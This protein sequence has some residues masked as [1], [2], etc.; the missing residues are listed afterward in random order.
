MD[1]QMEGALAKEF[2]DDCLSTLLKKA[3]DY[4]SEKDCFSNFKFIAQICK[5]PIEKTF[6]QFL[7][8]KIARLSELVGESKEVRNESIEDTLKDLAN[9]SCLMA[10]YMKGD[11]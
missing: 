7:A 9:Y 4:A 5:V 11:K 6:L 1:Y 2:Y 10:I 3:N 8:V